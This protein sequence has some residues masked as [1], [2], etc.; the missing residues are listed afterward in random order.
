PLSLHT[1]YHLVGTADGASSKLYVNGQ[2]VG[3]TSAGNTYT[4]Y[5][6]ADFHV[7]GGPIYGS[8][9]GQVDE[10]A[11]YPYALTGT[12]VANHYTASSQAISTYSEADPYQTAAFTP[13]GTIGSG[14]TFTITL[15]S[16]S[17]AQSISVTATDSSPA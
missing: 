12:Q 4:G 14:D 5:T 16:G 2:S 9:N 8:L 17:G 6:A 15:G 3:S 13:W 11:V 1:W 7:G 10:A